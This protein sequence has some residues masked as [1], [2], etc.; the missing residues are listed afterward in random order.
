MHKVK[1]SSENVSP[2]GG[3]N[4]LYDAI[5]RSGIDKQLDQSIGSRSIFAKYSY[6]NIVLSLFGLSAS[7]G[8]F[9][10]DI[11]TLKNKF[12]NQLFNTIPSA[13]TV[14]YVCQELKT[15]TKKIITKD[16]IEHQI[17]Y[18]ARLHEAM[19]QLSVKTGMLNGNEENVL[20]Y[21]NV[22]L[23]N[24]KQDSMYSYK[25]TRA[26]HPGIAFI[27]RIPVYLENHNGNT[28]AKYQQAESLSCCLSM[29]DKYKV[30]V[31]RFRADSAA[32]QKDIF[33][34][35]EKRC[36]NFYIRMMDFD[37]IRRECGQIKHW[38]QI[39]LNYQTLEVC[40]IYYPC[41]KS[42]K[43]YRI[44]VT[45]HKRKDQQADL[46]SGDAYTYQGI[47]TNDEIAAEKEIIKFYN[48]R[49][50]AEKSNSYL[51]NDFNL[52]HLPFMD[53]DTNTVYMYL[54]AM[55]AIIFEW[56]KT[57]LV[58]NQVQG[59]ELVSRTKAVCFN[60]VMVATHFVKHA[61]QIICKVYSSYTYT[62]LRI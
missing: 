26:Y 25:K 45:R 17:N 23:E 9:L 22:V 61:R 43:L 33:E 58:K 37:D 28:P 6:S 49:G 4:F 19:V 62:P 39:E 14:E 47:V 29:L 20:D 11:K 13:D 53:L 21:D 12:S 44:V 10:A 5:F 38:K 8:T 51:L 57:I 56:T 52:H 34:L 3:L 41:C 32:Y 48:Q 40:S 31:A 50:D 1:I 24:E 55:C 27:G 15:V 60:Y 54:M 35:M 59:I 7:Q 42:N 2:I 18:N 36:V 30:G 46:L 16:G